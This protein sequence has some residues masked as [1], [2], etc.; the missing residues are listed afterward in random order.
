METI[1]R[2]CATLAD[3]DAV[4]TYFASDPM[5]A[6]VRRTAEELRALGDSVRAEELDGRLKSARQEASRALRDRTDLYADDGRT[7][8]LGAH[9]FAV[10]TQPLDLTLVPDGDGLAFA[11]TGTDYRSPVTDPDF[12]ATRAHWDR[13]LPRSPPASTAPNTSPPACCGSTARAPSPPPTTCPPS[14][15]RP[16]RRRT[17]RGTSGACT[18]TTR[19][20]S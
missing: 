20:S 19:P 11:L 7:L 10:N 8:R 12:A 13:T 9:R 6:K 5:P 14:S 1:A 2:R 15:A 17:T 4:S 3:A 18:T 16:R